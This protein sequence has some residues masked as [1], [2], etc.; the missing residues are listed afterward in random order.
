[1][2]CEVFGR[3]ILEE[4]NQA[5]QSGDQSHGEAGEALRRA[6]PTLR[7]RLRAQGIQVELH[8]GQHGLKQAQAGRFAAERGH[9][10]AVQLGGFA[11]ALPGPG[12]VTAAFAVGTTSPCSKESF[13][14]VRS[15]WVT[16][17]AG[18]KIRVEDLRD[19]EGRLF[20]GFVRVV[21]S[22]L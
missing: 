22:G 4:V 10:G 16:W 13:K 3:Y 5:R 18:R 14:M 21:V 6:L 19:Q 11:G 15:V 20:V 1:M 12:R 8:L 9:G 17:V 7:R 2:S